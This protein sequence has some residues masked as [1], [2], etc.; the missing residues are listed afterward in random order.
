MHFLPRCNNLTLP[1]EN[2]DTDEQV[3]RLHETTDVTQFKFK[4]D[5]CTRQGS[6][7][8]KFVTKNVRKY[9]LPRLG[10]KGKVGDHSRF[11]HKTVSV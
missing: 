2:S 7:C 11:I 6:N 1:G 8:K 5:F 4:T 3:G 10:M 9:P